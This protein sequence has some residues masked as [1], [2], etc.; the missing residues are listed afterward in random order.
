MDSVRAKHAIYFED[1]PRPELPRT[2]PHRLGEEDDDNV[3]AIIDNFEG[4]LPG[5]DFS[6]G[7]YV[8]QIL[9][10]ASGL[11]E[12]DVERY[13]NGGGTSLDP[14]RNA[15]EDEFGEELDLFIED[16]F[17]NLL[18]DTSDNL[19]EIL[20]DDDIQVITQSQSMSE[21]KVTARLWEE[22]ETN[23]EFR[24]Q[25][26]REL[27]LPPNCDDD[28]LLQ[29]LVDR[30]D[31]VREGSDRVQEAQERYDALTVE[32]DDRGI[33]YTVSSGNLGG[34][35]QT[36]DELGVEGDSDFFH[37]AFDN[38]HTT[39]VGATDGEGNPA[40]FTSP[41]AGAEVAMDGEGVEAT[42]D[43]NPSSRNGTSYSTPQ[44][45]ALAVRMLAA[46]PDLSDEE[47]E[48]MMEDAASGEHEATL[49]AG[50][51]DPQQALLIARLAALRD[52]W[53]RERWLGRRVDLAQV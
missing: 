18:D 29:A 45:A 47:V 17:V 42:V 4:T 36:M 49:G 23:P 20:E 39:V 5:E 32:I 3:V 6:H 48:A 8:E 50:E 34:F 21:A 41:D 22:A 40:D 9:L 25:L 46:N 24:E 26:C 33:V 52:E 53:N 37:S 16:S 31:H 10:D 44:V 14:L 38:G 28:V 2:L 35:A 19:E 13:Q 7:E 11:S 12:D 27:G 51:V 1:G 43:G 15:D 30:V